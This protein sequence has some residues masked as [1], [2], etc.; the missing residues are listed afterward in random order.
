MPALMS[1][2]E[3]SYSRAG[4]NF[5]VADVAGWNFWKHIQ[6]LLTL[7]QVIITSGMKFWLLIK[8]LKSSWGISH[9]S[10]LK[11]TEVWS[12]MSGPNSRVDNRRFR[13]HLYLQL[14]IRMTNVSGTI[15]VPIIRSW[16]ST[17][18]GPSVPIVRSLWWDEDCPENVGHF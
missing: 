11:I 14:Q 1:T 10:Y 9:V 12:I 6:D 4:M 13:D 18:Q 5:L 17:F 15:S 7:L 16:R 3:S 2:E 8:V